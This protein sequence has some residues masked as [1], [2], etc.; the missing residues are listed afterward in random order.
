MMTK[1][2]KKKM[3][4]IVVAIF[5]ILMLAAFVAIYL[6][7]DM[8]KSNKTL[9]LKYMGK[10]AENLE[11]I[12]ETF[13]N[14][15]TINGKYEESTEI[16]VNYTENIG[17][18]SENTDNSINNLKITLD[19]QTDK[20]N[21]YDYKNVKLLNKDEQV[22]NVEYIQDGNNHGIKFSD[23]FNQYLLLEEN[24][25]ES[26]FEKTDMLKEDWYKIPL[27]IKK[28][29]NIFDNFK[30]NE[31]EME[32]LKEKYTKVISEN[33]STG[34]FEKQKNQKITIN[35]RPVFVNAY[36]LTLTKEQLNN[37]YIKLLETIKEDEIILKRIENLQEYINV[38][39]PY[40]GEPID[41]K[42]KFTSDIDKKIEEI[43]KNNIGSEETKI[44]IYEN[45]KQTVRT[46]IQTADYQIDMDVFDNEGKYIEFSRKEKETE[47]Q[48][49]AIKNDGNEFAIN[50]EDKKQRDPY[51]INI[52]T[53]KENTSKN[54]TMIYEVNDYKVEA[55][56]AQKIEKVEEFEKQVTLID[57]NSIQLDTLEQEQLDNILNKVKENLDE[58]LENVKKEINMEDIQEVEK[59]LG[60]IKDKTI[61]EGGELTEAEKNRF[62]S[63]FQFLKVGELSD[64]EMLETIKMF[65]ENIINLEIVSNTELKIEI[66]RNK[67]N[68]EYVN[69][70]KNFVEKEERN[71]YN[72]KVQNDDTGL[73]KYVIMEIVK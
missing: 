25:I 16:R 72:V 44:I 68:E 27:E 12:V 65:E 15:N 61:L 56:I 21:R 40:L 2:E 41:L 73:V 10:N 71:K 49:L 4:I 53:V 67:N 18:T 51:K 39:N 34:K 69:V 42:S 54:T 50:I 20:E 45:A 59:T 37:I 19:G 33:V 8:F 62:N 6:L 60:I 11:T 22:M 57:K 64:K 47:V 28:T 52:E 23:L 14:K 24:N 5:I 3:I 26:F 70:L 1:K 7:T 55:K 32:T 48:N 46:S 31:E 17:T 43:T 30:F 66:D 63:K 36:T 29:E 38:A 35:E 13:E 9:F 58:K